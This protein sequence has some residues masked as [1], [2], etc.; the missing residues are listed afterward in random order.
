M[1]CRPFHCIGCSHPAALLPPRRPAGVPRVGA[2]AFCAYMAG[3]CAAWLGDYKSLQCCC[4]LMGQR[5]HKRRRVV[6][7]GSARLGESGTQRASTVVLVTA[8]ARHTAA[9]CT[10]G[11]AHRRPGCPSGAGC[12][13]PPRSSAATARWSGLRQREEQ[14]QAGQ[15]CAV[16]ARERAAKLPRV[17]GAHCHIGPDNA[18][19]VCSMQV[20]APGRL[21]TLPQTHC[22]T[23]APFW[24]RSR[25]CQ[26][27]A[28]GRKP[29]H[30]THCPALCRTLDG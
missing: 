24:G 28:G 26:Q 18:Q 2:L 15:R 16:G 12:H 30:K 27:P 5:G 17:P 23:A 8:P 9:A 21:Q 25:V 10:P 3:S 22:P 6:G 4:Q 29:N 1:L 13:T 14:R 11:P 19:P 7:G 20:L